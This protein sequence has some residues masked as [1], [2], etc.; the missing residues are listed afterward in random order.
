MLLNVF[1][2][3]IPMTLSVDLVRKVEIDQLDKVCLAIAET[4]NGWA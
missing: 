1:Y 2:K 3:Y 4:E